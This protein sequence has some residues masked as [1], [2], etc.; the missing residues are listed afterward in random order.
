VGIHLFELFWMLALGLAMW[1][2]LRRALGT[3]RSAPLRL[4]LAAYLMADEWC[5][6]DRQRCCRYSSCSA[7]SR[8]RGVARPAAWLFVAGEWEAS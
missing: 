4:R 1:L 5:L 2:T 3:A 8:P 6:L 7:H